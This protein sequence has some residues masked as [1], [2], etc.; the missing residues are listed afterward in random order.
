[1][2]TT[3]RYRQILWRYRRDLLVSPALVLVGV[4]C[5]TIQP[6]FMATIV[7]EG[8]M[9][10]DLSVISRV[11]LQMILLSLLG[12]AASVTNIYLSTRVSVRFGA[13]LRGQLFGAIQ[14]LSFGAVDRLAPASLITRLANDTAK[15]QHVVMMSMRILLRS[16]LMLVMAVF[17]IININVSLSLIL[18]AVIPV[19]VAG[20][21]GI[22]RTGFRHFAR[23]Q[24]KID[25]LNGIVRE[26]LLNMRVVK[27]FV[28]EPFEERKFADGNEDL[29]VTLTRAGNIF[30]LF[31][32]AIQ[33]VTNAAMLL[34]LWLGGV[35]VISGEIRVGELVAFV[36]YLSQ[37]L[38]SLMMLS[39]IV[40]NVARAAASSGRVLEVMDEAAPT[41]RPARRHR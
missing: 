15:I 35:K 33:L 17:F 39:M 10:R 16:P 31:F 19:M 32:P 20:A 23:V 37:I 5:E 38:V 26:N 7:D 6:R 22:V 29:R 28:R 21:Y 13:D 40:T 14:R 2:D 8:V 27:S 9:P 25:R 1:M 24:L 34:L 41:P 12:F 36:N 11:G 4:I 3:R 30:V 18:L